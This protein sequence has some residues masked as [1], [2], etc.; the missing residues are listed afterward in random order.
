MAKTPPIRVALDIETTELH[1]EQDAILEV[2]AMKFQGEKILDTFE[3]FVAAVHAILYR[4]QRLT[5][6]KPEHLVGALHF[7]TFA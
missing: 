7:A 1:P 4:V 2:A 5:G 3:S 6:I